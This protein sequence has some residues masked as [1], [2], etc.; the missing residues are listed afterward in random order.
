MRKVEASKTKNLRKVRK[1]TEG[2]PEGCQIQVE[3]AEW[4][5]IHSLQGKIHLKWELDKI[6]DN[7]ETSIVMG[8]AR[9]R[10]LRYHFSKSQ[11]ASELIWI[12]N[13]HLLRNNMIIRKVIFLKVINRSSTMLETAHKRMSMSKM[14][15]NWW[16][17][18]HHS[19]TKVH[20][21]S[22]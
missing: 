7:P 13:N 5:Q 1:R 14:E 20:S 16:G 11:Q 17:M 2:R 12:L 10:A 15:F 3:W 18:V 19:S 21:E 4:H 8:A 6:W 9:T 22:T